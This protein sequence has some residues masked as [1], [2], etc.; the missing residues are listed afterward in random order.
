MKRTSRHIA[1][2]IFALCL[3]CSPPLE[4]ATTT[5]WAQNINKNTDWTKYDYQQVG[6]YCWA[7]V[8][9]SLIT[10]WQSNSTNLPTS[11]APTDTKEI[12]DIFYKAFPSAGKHVDVAL[13][14]FFSTYYPTLDYN[15]VHQKIDKW[16]TT[17]SYKD[18]S[19]IYYDLL[20]QGRSIGITYDG[21]T[22]TIWGA[23]FDSNNLITKVYGTDSNYGT[24]E[25]ALEEYTSNF[26]VYGESALFPLGF[27]KQVCSAN[28]PNDCKSE[29]FGTAF[30]YDYLVFGDLSQYT[31]SDTDTPNPNPPSG[32]DGGDSGSGGGSESGGGGNG[33]ESGGDSGGN[34]GGDSGGGNSGGGGDSGG[35]TT[36]TDPE[37][38]STPT[39]PS[40]NPKEILTKFHENAL[41][42]TNPA[43]HPIKST[44]HTNIKSLN[45]NHH[46]SN[47]ALFSKVSASA[48]GR[49]IATHTHFEH[50]ADKDL[51]LDNYTHEARILT[52]N[53]ALKYATFY[54]R[55]PSAIRKKRESSH[56]GHENNMSFF[57]SP[58][59]GYSSSKNGYSGADFGAIMGLQGYV[60]NGHLLGFQLGYSYANLRDSGNTI[61]S[62]T[63]N[64]G[65]HYA[66]SLPYTLFL[67]VR[68]DFYYFINDIPTAKHNNYGF[69]ASVAFGKT[70]DFKE[71]GALDLSVGV[72]YF[73]LQQNALTYGLLDFKR[74]M[75][76]LIYADI[77]ASYGKE[78]KSG[79]A[80]NF[81]V[82]AKILT[83]KSQSSATIATYDYQI[84]YNLATDK[85]YGYVNL[86]ASYAFSDFISLGAEFM[87]F[88][89]D[90]SIN[91][92]GFLNLKLQ[93]QGRAFGAKRFGFA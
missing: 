33:G 73:A 40:T 3:A 7:H 84:T 72:D 52:Q 46:K 27:Q 15:K 42:S 5:L 18:M 36:P 77:G 66:L 20:S 90:K 86:G 81:G 78:F 12:I 76:H 65:L 45:L 57:F 91:N 87:G 10:H 61:N 53:D 92:S 51:L 49:R 67:R 37:N 17:Y 38:P 56:D 70:I 82:G 79:F 16:N 41:K 14:W 68:G 64:A 29:G 32:G 44:A 62:N 19:A 48:Q 39:N 35:G 85:F 88:Y 21:H 58:F 31:K 50:Y 11:S 30:Y 63:L 60:A 34:S 9:A 4:A 89:G 24:A 47:T 28:N 43:S 69:G 22:I 8:S 6:D 80:L 23:D 93:W 2:E 25:G 59:A 1:L 54:K 74:K 13:S 71:S 83:T 26:I 75:H 55:T